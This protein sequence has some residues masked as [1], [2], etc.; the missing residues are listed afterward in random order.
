MAA[1]V[2]F[3]IE[4]AQT[5]QTARDQQNAGKNRSRCLERASEPKPGKQQNK[6]RNSANGIFD[7]CNVAGLIN[8]LGFEFHGSL[9]RLLLYCSHIVNDASRTF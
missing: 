9:P 7:K 5:G 1:E 2:A 6:Q 4:Q 3:L 8:D